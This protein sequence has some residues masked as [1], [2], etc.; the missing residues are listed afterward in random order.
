MGLFLSCLHSTRVSLRGICIV[1]WSC[2]REVGQHRHKEISKWTNEMPT[3]WD[4]GLPNRYSWLV[5]IM[6]ATRQRQRY[7][8]ILF[9]ICLTSKKTRNEGQNELLER[10]YVKV[11]HSEV[12]VTIIT[13]HISNNYNFRHSSNSDNTN[14]ITNTEHRSFNKIPIFLQTS[15]T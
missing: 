3:A 8:T 15:I 14:I 10:S 6:N 7:V 4:I 5:C 1:V 11:H 2:R 9:F 13:I 12:N